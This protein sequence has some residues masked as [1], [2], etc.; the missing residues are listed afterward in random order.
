MLKEKELVEIPDTKL[1]REC[2][3]L[4]NDALSEIVKKYQKH[5]KNLRLLP[6]NVTLTFMWETE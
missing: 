4:I 6:E 3:K 5:L 2:E 1:E